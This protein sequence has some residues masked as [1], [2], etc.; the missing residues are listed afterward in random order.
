[1]AQGKTYSVGA[2]TAD[3]VERLRE[4]MAEA[5]GFQP[6]YAQVLLYAATHAIECSQ[7]ETT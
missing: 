1:M 4:L 6:T 7:K 2:E 3:A 5:A